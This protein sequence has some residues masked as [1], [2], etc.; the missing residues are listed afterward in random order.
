[1]II[2]AFGANEDGAYGAPIETY[3]QAL[4]ALDECGLS[5][6]KK[7]SLWQTSPVDVTGAQNDYTN[8]VFE[9]ET[10]QSPHEIL[11][12]LL[13]VE[14][15]FGRKRTMRNAPRSIDLDLICYHDRIVKELNLTLPH[16]RMHERG[17]VLWPLQEIASNWQHPLTG[18]SIQDLIAGLPD[19][20]TAERIKDK[21]A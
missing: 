14:A 3:N 7:S 11:E 20:Q 18:K 10:D 4:K 19:D 16:P 13:D 6:A 17:F 12:I 15:E 5:I 21:A 9:I 1:M 2:V 8:A